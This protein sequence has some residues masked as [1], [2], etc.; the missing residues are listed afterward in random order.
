MAYYRPMVSEHAKPRVGF[1]TI[2]PG[3]TQLILTDLRFLRPKQ[4]FPKLELSTLPNR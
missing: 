3:Q 1:C 4:L 2:I